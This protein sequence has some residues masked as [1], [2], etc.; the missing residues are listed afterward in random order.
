MIQSKFITQIFK[1][2]QI[3][4]WA[5]VSSLIIF[6]IFILNSPDWYT[7]VKIGFVI[8]FI[9]VVVLFISRRT[10]FFSKWFLFDTIAMLIIG[11][12]ELGNN[13]TIHMAAGEDSIQLGLLMIVLLNLMFGLSITFIVRYIVSKR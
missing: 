6:Y 7:A 3:V 9:L 12:M 13:G 1:W 8:Q 10:R 11:L 4:N 2:T 5:V